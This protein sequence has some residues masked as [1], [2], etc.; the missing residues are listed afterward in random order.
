MHIPTKNSLSCAAIVFISGFSLNI[1]ISRTSYPVVMAFKSSNILAVLLVAIFCTRVRDKS[2][3][4]PA[5][6]FIIGFIIAVGVFLF[7][8]FDPESKT[9]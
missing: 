6:K 4:L 1:A 7:G 9:R 5:K 8:Y 2:L 3:N